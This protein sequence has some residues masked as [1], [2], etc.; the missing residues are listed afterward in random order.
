MLYT[1]EHN[2][3]ELGLGQAKTAEDGDSEMKMLVV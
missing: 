2:A 3:A 1:Q